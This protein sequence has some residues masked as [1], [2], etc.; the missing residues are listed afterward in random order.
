MLTVRSRLL[1][2]MC[3]IL[4]VSIAVNNYSWAQPAPDDEDQIAADDPG[5]PG[6]DPD[7]PIDTNILLLVA[8][9][10]GYGLKK[11]WDAK[12]TFK[13]K[14]NSLQVNTANFEDYIK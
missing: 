10:V 12:H 9:G 6:G 4:M 1:M 13:R 2:R 7:L 8:A 14:Q 11:A 3:L 5:D